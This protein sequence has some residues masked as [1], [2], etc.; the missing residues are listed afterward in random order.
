MSLTP[1]QS[2]AHI[3]RKLHLLQLADLFWFFRLYGLSRKGNNRFR[4]RYPGV[5][6]PPLMMLYDIQGNCDLSGFYSSGQ[7]HALEIARTISDERP[8]QSLKVL[9]WGCGPARV[10]QHLKAVNDDNWELW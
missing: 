7:E 2:L 5:P 1:L 4:Q 6:V 10:L 8:R 3:L 9:E